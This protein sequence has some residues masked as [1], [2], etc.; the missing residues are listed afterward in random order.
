MCPFVLLQ[1]EEHLM[2]F[3]IGNL[4]YACGANLEKVSAKSWDQNEAYPQLQGDHCVLDSGYSSILNKLTEG[5]DV[6]LGIKVREAFSKSFLSS[7]TA[8]FYRLFGN[9]V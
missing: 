5:L 3:H 4:E 2:Q 9:N 7:I 1:E 6:R 8:H